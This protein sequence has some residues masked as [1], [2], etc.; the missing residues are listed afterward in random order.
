MSS[1]LRGI[2]PLEL[3][4][5]P[6]S[7]LSICSELCSRAYAFFWRKAA[8][9]STFYAVVPFGVSAFISD[10]KPLAAT[11]VNLSIPLLEH[12]HRTPS[13]VRKVF[14]NGSS[15][16][17]TTVITE[18][19]LG[20][21]AGSVV[22]PEEPYIEM[23]SVTWFGRISSAV[24]MAFAY[25]FMM[26]AMRLI[27]LE[28]FVLPVTS[29]HLIMRHVEGVLSYLRD[30]FTTDEIW[31]LA[32]GLRLSLISSQLPLTPPLHCATVDFIML[33]YTVNQVIHCTVYTYYVISFFDSVS[34]T[35]YRLISLRQ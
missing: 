30:L 17:A 32:A 14:S 18:Q 16:T 13:V 12:L 7:W 5:G 19:H 28:D 31:Q 23:E 35:V 21:N 1:Q 3:S 9:L 29:D 8:S 10:W 34:H 15:S 6:L 2:H 27:S 20:S 11:V 24:D 22:R 25:P 33:R 4:G 26:L